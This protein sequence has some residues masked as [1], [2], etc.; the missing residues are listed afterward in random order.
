MVFKFAIWR[1][2]VARFIGRVLCTQGLSIK[3][4]YELTDIMQSW[5]KL[6]STCLLNAAVA[7]LLTML[8][9]VP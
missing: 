1:E 7:M 8:D 3:E 9:F 5:P 4:E 2:C 6:R